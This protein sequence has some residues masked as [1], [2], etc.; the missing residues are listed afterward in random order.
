MLPYTPYVRS[1]KKDQPRISI[2]AKL[3][4]QLLRAAG[5]GRATMTLHSPQ[6][7]GFFDIPVI[8]CSRR[9]CFAATSRNYQ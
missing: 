1:D 6:I 3:M 2:T 5:A 9:R 7:Q 4:A 8:T